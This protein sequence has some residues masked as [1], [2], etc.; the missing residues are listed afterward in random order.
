MRTRTAV[1]VVV[2]FIAVKA[3]LTWTALN[4]WASYTER[5]GA[6]HWHVELGRLAEWLAAGAAAIAAI[7]ALYIAGRDRQ[8]R[9]AERHEE[10][11]THARLVRLSVETETSRPAVIVEARKFDRSATRPRHRPC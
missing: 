4:S 10:Q 1:K 7:M 11:K 9:I 8:Q 3:A 2:G 6:H 5:P